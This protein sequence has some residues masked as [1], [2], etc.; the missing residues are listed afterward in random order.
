MWDKVKLG[1]VLKQYRQEIWVQDDVLYKQLSITKKEGIKQRGFKIGS[2]I[3][4]KRQFVVDLENF[5]NTIMFTRQT[6][7]QDKAI[8]LAPI[9]VNNAIVTENMPTL[10]VLNNVLPLFI[11]H[12][13]KSDIFFKQ[14][15]RITALGSAQQ[16]IHE[17]QFLDFEI[18]LPPL[19]EQLSIVEKLENATAKL[20][21]IKQL[22]AESLK[23][24]KVLKDIFIEQIFNKLAQKYESKYFKEFCDVVRGGSPRPAGDP[25][26]YGGKIPFLKVGDLTNDNDIYI[27]SY[28]ETITELGLY[29]TRL[30][31]KGTLLLTNSGATLGVP[32]ITPFQTTFNDGIQAFI[33][34]T[35]EINLEYLYCFFS[36]KTQYFRETL[37]QGAAQP[38]LKTEM[39][40]TLKVPI[41][42]LTVQNQIVN[43]IKNYKEKI[44]TVK[45][46]Q[47][48]TEAEITAMEKSVLNKYIQT[49]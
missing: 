4:R 38:N 44:E 41:P 49:N 18:P 22:R 12:F 45:Q 48:Q 16:A 21:Q 43:Q 6:I 7:Q 37:A 10:E 17:R 11:I 14:L 29:K 40:K 20:K 27:Q 35:Q 46:L 9:E 36:S 2:E 24:M 23:E 33:N 47:Q 15:D 34:F 19:S 31:E 28:K 8:G 32:K 39:I 30:V 1:K 3:G 25:T 26:Y 13:L 5:P 42:P